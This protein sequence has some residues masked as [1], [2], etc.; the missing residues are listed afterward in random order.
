[1]NKNAYSTIDLSA[2]RSAQMGIKM[3][4]I[5]YLSM[6]LTL[7]IIIMCPI[8]ASARSAEV[9]DLDKADI[10]LE[11]NN[12]EIGVAFFFNDE[13]ITMAYDTVSE[14]GTGY[15]YKTSDNSKIADFNCTGTFSYDGEICNVT[16]VSTS[17]WGTI[18]GY[19]V[20]VSESTKQISPTYARATGVFELYK[21]SFWGDKLTSS[22]TINVFCNQKGDTDVEFNS[23]DE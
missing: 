13:L 22:A 3:K 23:D 11:T 19:K 21:L 18:E 4:K 5:K 2:R 1:M 8:T 14:T 9:I 6:V 10:I 17:V 7:M 16:D 15:F 12:S 20:E